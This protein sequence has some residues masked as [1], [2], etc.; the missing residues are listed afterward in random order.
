MDKVCY[1]I[2]NWLHRAEYTAETSRTGTVAS[3]NIGGAHLGVTI[4]KGPRGGLTYEVRGKKYRTRKGAFSALARRAG[5][6]CH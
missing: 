1:Q 6:R 5:K 4:R 2:L 3:A